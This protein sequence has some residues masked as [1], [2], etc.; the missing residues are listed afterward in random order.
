MRD[1]ACRPVPPLPTR[2]CPVSST[3]SGSAGSGL[4]A[5]TASETYGD[6]W[7]QF[8][9]GTS[10]WIASCMRCREYALRVVRVVVARPRFVKAAGVSRGLGKIAGVHESLVHTG[11]RFAQN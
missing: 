2:I 8:S 3:A 1:G 4:Q 5:A 10:D 11:Q 6:V 9:D 7:S